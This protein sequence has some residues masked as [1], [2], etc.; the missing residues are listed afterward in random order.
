MLKKVLKNNS[1]YSVG[2]DEDGRL[3][4]VHVVQYIQAG[5]SMDHSVLVSDFDNS[6]LR[7]G[8]ES[9]QKKRIAGTLPLLQP[10]DLSL[11]LV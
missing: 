4:A 6:I 5:Y 9:A 2:I 8:Q 11:H 10:P 7:P 3:L 1:G